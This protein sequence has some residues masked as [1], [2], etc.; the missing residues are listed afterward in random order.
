MIKS[1][2]AVGLTVLA[3]WAPS[4]LAAPDLVFTAPPRGAGINES[5]VYQPVA[6]YLSAA[7]GK[8]IVYKHSDNWLSYQDEMRKGAYDLVFDGPHF[9]SWRM[10]KLGHEPL[11]KLP[12]KLT[13]VV[14]AKKDNEKVTS[15]KDLAGRLVCGLAPPNLA[16]LTMY[17]QF[18]NPVRQ[19]LIVE[20]ASF[21]A[22]YENLVKGKC[23]GAVM[24]IGIFNGLDK[25]KSAAKVLY[26][27]E[28]IANQGFSASNRFTPEQ[29][30]KMAEA[31]VAPEA[32][33]K[34]AK[35][36]EN[37]NKDKDLAKA[38]K[39]EYEGVA[40]LLKDVWGFDLAQNSA[41]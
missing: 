10:V 7:I 22:A 16:T 5:D 17:V 1:M 38:V 6:D 41:K 14:V 20:V 32:K 13:F 4:A 39:T 27:S 36:F 18:D 40:V 25:D 11:A 26:K 8:K 2:T 15:L 28:G 19:P 12:G 3:L 37:Y 33:V 24:P 29:K 23:V 30:A 34:M 21:K 9:I 31:L 35:F